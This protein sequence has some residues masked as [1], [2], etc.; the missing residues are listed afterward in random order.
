MYASITLLILFILFFLIF[1]SILIYITNNSKIVEYKVIKTPI[2]KY[3]KEIINYNEIKNKY[4]I[5]KCTEM[6]SPEICNE[7]QIQQIKYDL[8]KEC[9]KEFKCYNPIKGT[10]EFC[11]NFNS[12]DS[13]YGCNDKK[14]INPL[15][16]YCKKCWN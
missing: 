13:L 14:L 4:K 16:N 10:C 15:N 5:D 3:N 8:C 1:F 2:E 12:C 9:S 6:C 7:Y 11:L